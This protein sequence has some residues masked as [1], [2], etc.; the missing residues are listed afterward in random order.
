MDAL[1]KDGEVKGLRP[2]GCVLVS[3]QVVEQSV[4]LD[5]DLLVTE[6]APTDMLL[7]RIGRLWRHER[8]PRPVERAECWILQ[9]NATLDEL[10]ALGKEKI[11]EAFGAKAWVYAPYVLLRTLEEWSSPCERVIKIP[12][13]IRSLLEATYTERGNEP[14]GWEAWKQEIQGDEFAKK[15]IAHMAANIW[16]PML[17]D[18]E[19]VQTRIAEIKTVQLILST[20]LEGKQLSLL[21]SE[22]A[23]LADDIFRLDTARALHKNLVKVPK[24]VFAV[25]KVENSKTSRYVKGEQT[26]ATV[27]PDGLVKVAGLKP[28]YTIYWHNDRG[29]VIRRGKEGKIDHESCD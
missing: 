7:Q 13:E 24:S 3:T 16:N 22:R 4:D 29:L 15:Q 5:A 1:G 17:D 27:Q 12:S 11:R 9:E 23:N 28:D 14:K 25:K 10:R 26:I 19:G 18:H 21:S 2:N 8:G 20:S 6:L